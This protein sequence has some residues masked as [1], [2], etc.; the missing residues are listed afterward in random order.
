MFFRICEEKPKCLYLGCQD[1][2]VTRRMLSGTVGILGETE[3]TLPGTV[4]MLSRTAGML[5]VGTLGC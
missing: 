5:W 1:R 4:G 3:G 2:T